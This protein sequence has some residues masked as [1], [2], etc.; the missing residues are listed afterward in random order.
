[1][2]IFNPKQIQ[3]FEQALRKTIPKYNVLTDPL[4]RHAYA[5]DASHYL[6]IPQIVV[7]VES[8]VDIKWVFTCANKYHIPITIR[9]AGTSLSG[10][11]ISEYC[12]VVIGWHWRKYS[13][14]DNGFCINLQPG[15]IAGEANYYLKKYQRKI[16]PDP[17]SIDFAKIGGIVANNASGMCCGTK[18]NSYQTLKHIRV[19]L[20]DGTTLD[21][22]SMESKVLFKARNK[23]IIEKIENI[24][25]NINNNIELKQKIITKYQLKNTVGY[26]LNAFID[27]HDPIEI[28]SH[29]FVGS[30]GTLG[31]ISEVGLHTIYDEPVKSVA[32]F[33]FPSAKAAMEVVKF[34]NKETISS[35]EFLDYSSLLCAK[36]EITEYIPNNYLLNSDKSCILIIDIRSKNKEECQLTI[37]NTLTALNNLKQH[38]FH[39]DFYFDQNYNKI[40]QIR[41]AILPVVQAQR[42]ENAICL[43]EDIAFPVDK[44]ST[45][46]EDLYSLFQTYSFK[47]ACVFGHAKDGNLHFLIEVNFNNKVEIEKYALFMEEL[48]KIVVIKYNGSLKAEHGTGRNIAPFVETEWGKEATVIMQEIKKI[49]DPK[50]YLNPDVILASDNKIHLKHLKSITSID[51]QF[52]KCTECGNCERICPSTGYTLTPRQRI[53][54]LRAIAHAK[55]QNNVTLAKFMLKEFKFKGADTC[56]ASSMCA[57]VCPVKVDTGNVIKMWRKQ[58]R[59]KI[60]YPLL[61]AISKLHYFVLL[62]GKIFLFLKGKPS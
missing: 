47:N 24:R 58:N 2:R 7:I 17:A 55:K 18:Y 22:S 48:S 50:Y 43:L 52:D 62:V 20:I 40:M 28:I 8:E 57:T 36:N 56:A 46:I 34:L 42:N 51:P 31:F 60:F 44:L 53:V 29:L 25:E 38:I 16:G 45:A 10:Q 23:A 19:I 5:N 39:T 4:S 49:F 32:I 15:V 37:E 13:I 3:K 9:A 11:A 1:M 59:N 35:L 54:S 6:L 33:V 12:L 26:S 30:E 21:T 41:K 27:Y 61:L 14:M